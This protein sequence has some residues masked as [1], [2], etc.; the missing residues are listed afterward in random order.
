MLFYK[1]LSFDFSLKETLTMLT[2]LV[3]TIRC[4]TKNDIG[5]YYHWYSQK[6]LQKFQQFHLPLVFSF[7]VWQYWI[8]SALSRPSRFCLLQISSPVMVSL[9]IYKLK[10]NAKLREKNSCEVKHVNP[11]YTYRKLCQSPTPKF[12]F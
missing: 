3:K 12:C 5:R 1:L 8:S 6:N 11:P 4:I 9:N 7:H 10:I 2:M